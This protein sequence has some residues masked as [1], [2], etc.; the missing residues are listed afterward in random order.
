[1]K[2][3]VIC[4]FLLL[5]LYSC[6]NYES[7]KYIRNENNA[8]QDLIPQMIKIDAILQLYNSD[9]DSLTL[10]L[11]STLDTVVAEIYEPDG[12]VVAINGIDLKEEDIRKRRKVTIQR[13]RD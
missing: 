7:E 3:R 2:I 12:F 10:L 5:S 9:F 13:P 8:I 11:N 6:R 4:T 1:M